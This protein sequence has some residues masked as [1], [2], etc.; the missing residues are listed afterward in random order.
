MKKYIELKS[1]DRVVAGQDEFRFRSGS[2]WSE[3]KKC[4]NS[5]TLEPAH[6]GNDEWQY[7]RQVP[8]TG[9][10]AFLVNYSP[11][12]RVEVDCDG[13]SEEEIYERVAQAAQEK[14]FATA[15]EYRE[16]FH[17]NIDWENTKVDEE[18]PADNE[19]KYRTLGRGELVEVGDE[20][21]T[22]DGNWEVVSEATKKAIPNYKVTDVDKF[23]RPIP[24][25]RPFRSG[26]VIEEG[27]QFVNRKG[28]W[29]VFKTSII[30]DRATEAMTNHPE[31]RKLVK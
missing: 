12:I 21:F 16:F 6:F 11:I 30:E 5:P 14:F 31:F 20:F 23:R 9:K 22:R 13:L 17:E 18:C 28:E 15:S 1:G 19:P 25:Y 26:D 4:R 10:T 27:D 29:T 2:E 8:F 24:Q 7:R 3:W